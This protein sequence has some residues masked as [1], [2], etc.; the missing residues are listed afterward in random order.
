[1][2]A[3]APP[4]AGGLVPWSPPPAARHP[5]AVYLARL[6]R[7]SRPAQRHA[8]D[9]IARLATRGRVPRAELMPWPELRYQHTAAIRALLAERYRP[10]TVNR[11]VAALRGV[12]R[13]CWRLELMS[14]ENYHR[15]AD[16]EIVR[17]H[18]LPRGRELAPGEIVALFAACGA[19][20][21]GARD[22]ALLACLYGAGLRRAELAGLEIRDWSPDT[23]AIT[24]RGGKG[25]RDRIVY[26]PSGAIAAIQVWITYRGEEP[27][28]LLFAI[29]KDGEIQRHG[30]TPE[31]I[32][33]A[34]GRIAARA[35]VR[36]FTPHDL[37]RSFVSHLLAGGVDLVTVQR[38]VGH[39]SPEMTARYDRRG[40]QVKRDAA[41]LLH[42]PFAPP[43]TEDPI[44]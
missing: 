27:G 30:L 36:A 7:G 24:V 23:G 40:E 18:G 13:E 26:A 29:R 4:P 35:G 10:A 43:P 25:A 42:V 14:A 22:A 39:A 12:L 37:R 41:E 1:M 32:R 15:A 19:G 21:G 9:T 8:L 31:A 11:H 20:A 16:I 6:G 2:S 3:I 5:V 44:L 28:P 38:L 34:L 17:G 33:S